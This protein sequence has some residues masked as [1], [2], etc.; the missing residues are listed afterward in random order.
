MDYLCLVYLDEARL[1]AL[2]RSELE[3]L[4]LAIAAW[5][6]RLRRRHQCLALHRLAPA[7]LATTVRDQPPR[8]HDGPCAGEREQLSVVALIRALHLDQALQLAAALPLAG[9]G[10]VE[11]RPLAMERTRPA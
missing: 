11:V 1:A 2:P 7:R 10:G 8:L 9:L 6:A 3:S 4:V 5:E